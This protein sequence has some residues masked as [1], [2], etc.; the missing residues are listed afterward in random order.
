MRKYH[1]VWLPC[2]EGEGAGSP[3][4]P[5]GGAF[6]QEQVNAMLA[7]ERRKHEGKLTTVM[8]EIEALKTRTGLTQQERDELESR[9][10]QA[11]SEGQTKEQQL[12]EEIKKL[13]KESEK[14]VNT[15]SEQ[16]K[17]YKSRFENTLIV[18][19]ITRA[20]ATTGAY[21]PEQIEAILRPKAILEEGLDEEGKPTGEFI[22]RV[23]ILAMSDDGKKVT[24]KLGIE[25]AV[26]RMK[27]DEAYANLFRTSGAG[28]MGGGNAGSGKKLN[29]RE[30][31]K[32]PRAYREAREAGKI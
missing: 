11:M 27:E 14:Q 7:E 8:G 2:F 4:A 26:K 23:N 30:L 24:L 5:S 10:K 15:L 31:A 1:K 16:A 18:N 9:L 20:A 21:N 28:G 17:Q 6:T 12:T 25:D 3:A 19:A 29:I 13:R 22:P 32:N